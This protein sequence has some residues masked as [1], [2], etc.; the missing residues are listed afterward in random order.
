MMTLTIV[1]AGNV[2]ITLAKKLDLVSDY[3]LV[4]HSQKSRTNALE[5][6][7]PAGKLT[8]WNKA[9]FDGEIIVICVKDSDLGDVVK[10]LCEQYH[11]QLKGKLVF[12][13]S[14]T[15]PKD[16]LKELV[17]HGAKIAAVHPF[18]TF[19]FNEARV[20]NGITW[21]VDSE[22]EDFEAISR[23][24]DNINGKA[25]KLSA[26]S[27]KKK[28]LY[29]ISAVAASNFMALSIDLA[30]EL[31]EEA[32]IDASVFLPQIL[33]TT[34]Q[35]N[36]KQLGSDTPAITGPVVRGDVETIK[37]HIEA[38]GQTINTVIYKN[39][40]ESLALLAFDKGLLSGEKFEQIMEILD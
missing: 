25:I 36:I 34:L 29:H 35:N 2:G 15:L 12:H 13:T 16:S 9:E 14:G 27:V 5:G 1:G 24:I 40:C 20:L 8:D 3:E 37:K 30:K 7:L 26:E 22:E 33:E 4:A 18:Q 32:G 10:Q 38:L 21:G 17:Q 19:Y 11:E 6:G 23:F 28:A 31:A 39:M